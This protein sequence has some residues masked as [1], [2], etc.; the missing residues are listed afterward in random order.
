MIEIS[1]EKPYRRTEDWNALIK[2]INDIL[3]CPPPNTAC[4]GLDLIAEVDPEHIFT[5]EDVQE[6]RDALK[7]TCPSIVFEEPLTTWSVKLIQEIQDKEADAWCDC[8]IA[9]VFLGTMYSNVEVEDW[10]GDP[11]CDSEDRHKLCSEIMEVVYPTNPVP[12]PAFDFIPINLLNQAA[13]EAVTA[14]HIFHFDA[15]PLGKIANNLRDVI[16]PDLTEQLEAAAPGSQAAQD[17][18]DQLDAAIE[19]EADNRSQYQT[20]YDLAMESANDCEAHVTTAQAALN[21][22]AAYDSDNIVNLITLCTMRLPW[23]DIYK[24]L[25]QWN[26]DDDSLPM[27]TFRVS[28]QSRSLGGALS[29]SAHV[30]GY[31]YLVTAPISGR[32]IQVWPVARYHASFVRTHIASVECPWMYGGTVTIAEING[33]CADVPFY[34]MTLDDAVTAYSAMYVSYWFSYNEALPYIPD[35]P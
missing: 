31:P 23:I 3:C 26:P 22:L 7:K 13:G 8:E 24:D 5:V 18:Q 1:S 12:P 10:E 30:P 28:S 6:A 17:I 4:G 15:N 16:I 25:D 11:A 27:S 33:S 21:A 9:D 35:T 19:S 20:N 14:A 29:P 32:P 2:E 34:G